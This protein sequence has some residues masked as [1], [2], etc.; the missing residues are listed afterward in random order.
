M[1]LQAAVDHI[2]ASTG[3]S[4]S[5]SSSTDNSDNSNNNNNPMIRVRQLH[6]PDLFPDHPRQV[7]SIP[8]VAD[9]LEATLRDIQFHSLP[10]S[11]SSSFT[12]TPPKDHPLI[13]LFT[14][15]QGGVSGHWN[16]RDTY[17]CVQHVVQRNTTANIIESAWCLITISNPIQKYLPVF[18]WSRWLLFSVMMMLVW[19]REGRLEQ[20]HCAVQQQQRR[21]GDEE[22]EYRFL[23][24]ALNW[25]L[26]QAHRSQFVWYR[27]LFVIFS[28]YTYCNRFR[29][30]R[31]S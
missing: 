17:F 1:E 9:A 20:Q 2:I 31:Q 7:W 26:M 15:D 18:E 4:L 13:R 11:S 8:I 30:I 12:T 19:R 24:P 14:F 25:K 10:S 28:C 22:L 29:R 16:H 27:R 5:S 21:G 6:Q 23:N 3:S